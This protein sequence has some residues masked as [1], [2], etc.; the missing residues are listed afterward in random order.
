MGQHYGT[1]IPRNGLVLHVDAANPKSYPGS[2]N[3][4]TDLSKEDNQIT[5]YTTPSITENSFDFTAAYDDG[6][7]VAN[8]S[9]ELADFSIEVVFKVLGTHAHYD[10][11]LVSSGN[12]N[13]EHW[14]LSITQNNASIR[15]R[16]PSRTV[17]HSFTTDTWYHL[18]YTRIGSSLYFFLNGDLIDSYTWTGFIP[19]DSNAS[20][21]GIGRETYAGGYF[22]LNGKI[23]LAKIYEVGFSESRAKSNFEVYRGRFGI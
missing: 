13:S 8:N 22:N 15:T 7:T 18:V 6:L 9:F 5:F 14:A 2:G 4:V 20:N 10:G 23:A 16:N 3:S 12:W 17:S 19:L 11:A 21:T 1:K